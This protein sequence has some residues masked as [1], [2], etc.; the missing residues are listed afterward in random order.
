MYI[1]ETN[2]S[3]M[4]KDLNA[5]AMFIHDLYGNEVISFFHPERLERT[6]SAGLGV[7][8]SLA[9]ELAKKL[10]LGEHQYTVLKCSD[11]NLFITSIGDKLLSLFS[12]EN[13]DPDK[14]FEKVVEQVAV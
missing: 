3:Q 8:L 2:V 9:E 1:S 14:F 5:Y 6:T 13:I 12:K 4:L 10:G 11:G 7:I